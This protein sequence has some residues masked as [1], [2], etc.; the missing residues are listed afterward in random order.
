MLRL[1]VCFESA[2]FQL[3]GRAHHHFNAN[4][5]ASWGP[6]HRYHCRSGHS[7][8]RNSCGGLSLAITPPIPRVHGRVWPPRWPQKTTPSGNHGSALKWAERP[9]RTRFRPDICRAN[10]TNTAGKRQHCQHIQIS[11]H[12]E[13][14]P[15]ISPGPAAVITL[16]AE[17]TGKMDSNAPPLRPISA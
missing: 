6:P 16:G 12:D 17:A 3:S 2:L 4:P 7:S 15:C 9:L 14:L 1:V 10:A 13:Q 11:L 8:G 5:T